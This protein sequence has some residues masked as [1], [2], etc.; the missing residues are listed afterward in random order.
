MRNTGVHLCSILLVHIFCLSASNKSID[1]HHT[2]AHNFMQNTKK[3]HST[4]HKSTKTEANIVIILF[5]SSC[6]HPQ[7]CKS[8]NNVLISLK[9]VNI[10]N[11]YISVCKHC[12]RIYCRTGSTHYFTMHCYDVLLFWEHAFKIISHVVIHFPY[13]GLHNACIHIT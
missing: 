11:C 4:K 2:N 5:V 10:C 12:I 13:M 1:E 3:R 7:I 6:W 9:D 8:L